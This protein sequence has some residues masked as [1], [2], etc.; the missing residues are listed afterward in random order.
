MLAAARARDSR[1][2]VRLA[3][4][5]RVRYRRSMS[6]PPPTVLGWLNEPLPFT[7]AVPLNAPRATGVLFPGAAYTQERPLCATTRDVFVAAGVETFLSTRYYGMDP[8]LS[9]LTGEEREACLVADSGAFA[10][11]AFERSAGKPVLLAGKSI[12]TTAMAHALT[13]VPDLA[14][15]WSIW[16]TP[17]WKDEAIF[18]AIAA[19]GARAFVLIGTA[20]PQWDP[21][22]L[23]ALNKKAKKVAKSLPVVV[24]VEGADHGMAVAGQ[25]AATAKVLTD[26]KPALVAHVAAAL[27]PPAPPAP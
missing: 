20:D 18:K 17:L 6:I 7:M 12:G 14:A 2:P 4:A 26:L 10:R 23:E 16:L 27:A 1:R 13:Q 9:A 24:V 8:K 15:G 19:A 3:A 11:A 25:P 22:L 21:A 5:G